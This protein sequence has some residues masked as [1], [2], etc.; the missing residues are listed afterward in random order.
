MSMNI[1]MD[2]IP[3]S[4]MVAY[5]LVTS[6]SRTQICAVS[7]NQTSPVLLAIDSRLNVVKTGEKTT[8]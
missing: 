7:V 1:P 4:G 5:D 8:G 2:F 6:E 3:I